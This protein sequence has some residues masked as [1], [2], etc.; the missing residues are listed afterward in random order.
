[1]TP[2]CPKCGGRLRY[3]PNYADTPTINCMNCGWI[4]QKPRVVMKEFP[5]E[6]PKRQAQTAAANAAM[7]KVQEMRKR[8]FERGDC[9]VCGILPFVPGKMSCQP[10]LDKKATNQKARK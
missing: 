3:D 9:I 2:R 7:T 10:C 4:K 8:R 5:K 6:D 1:M